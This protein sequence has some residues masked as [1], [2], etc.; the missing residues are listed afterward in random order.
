MR[1]KLFK[2]RFQI[3]AVGVS[4]EFEGALENRGAGARAEAA[5]EERARPISDDPGGI[6]IVFLS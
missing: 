5:I 3:E 6:E 1:G 2:R 4:A